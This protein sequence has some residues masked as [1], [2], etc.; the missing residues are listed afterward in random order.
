MVTEI[1]YAMKSFRVYSAVIIAMMF[2]SLTFIWFKIANEV[3]RPL[4][5]VFL[6]LLIAVVILSLYLSVTRKFVKIRK[7]DRRMFIMMSVFEPFIYFLGESFGLTYVSST[8]GSVII[9]TIPVFSVLGAWLI[10][11]EKL[12][13]I[14]YTGIALSFIGI[15]IFIL[16]PDGT[17]SFNLRGLLLLGVAVF[18]AIGY[19]LT[20]SRLAGNYNPVLAGNQSRPAV[21]QGHLFP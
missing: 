19:N 21:L 11:R 4:S 1:H 17:L 2:W 16:R 15:L 5:I 13:L 3:Y 18:A 12:R 7:E 9:S 6:R 10:F 8:T 14:N 20:L